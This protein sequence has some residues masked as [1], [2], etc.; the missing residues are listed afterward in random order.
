MVLYLT[1]IKNNSTNKN[2]LNEYCIL[3]VCSLLRVEDFRLK[4]WEIVPNLYV[5]AQYNE[6]NELNSNPSMCGIHETYKGYKDI[7]KGTYNSSS[8]VGPVGV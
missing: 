2:V 3:I 4:A 1:I 6:I 8:N 7:V 5:L